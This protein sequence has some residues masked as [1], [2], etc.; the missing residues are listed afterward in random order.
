MNLFFSPRFRRVLS[1]GLLLWQAMLSAVCI[2]V[3]GTE[4]NGSPGSVPLD[5]AFNILVNAV[6]FGRKTFVPPRFASLLRSFP[7]WIPEAINTFPDFISVSAVP[8]VKRRKFSTM[9]VCLGIDIRFSCEYMYFFKCSTRGFDL[10]TWI[11]W[12]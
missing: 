9:N 12:N 11:R 7:A 1:D 5:A 8:T 4:R 2:A 10:I 6:E 3:A